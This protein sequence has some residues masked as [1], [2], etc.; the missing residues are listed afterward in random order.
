MLIFLVIILVYSH[1]LFA[2]FNF[3]P[4]FAR[5]IYDMLFITRGK[6]SLIGP[7]TSFGGI[8]SGPYYYYLFVPIFYLTKLNIYSLL[9]FN[10][11]LFLFALI[12]FYIQIAKRYG[13]LSGTLSALVIAFLPIYVTHSRGPWNGS[14]YLPF[15]LIFLTLLFFGEFKKNEIGLLLLGFFAGLIATIHLTNVL[16]LFF[17]SIYLLFL[18]KRKVDIVYFLAGTTLVFSPLILFEFK[19]DFIMLKNTFIIGSYK[20]FIESKNIPPYFFFSLTLLLIFII[21]IFL[22]NI[23]LEYLLIIVLILEIYSFPKNIYNYSP[24][25]PEKY[26]NAVEYV[27]DNKLIQKGESFNIFQYSED[28]KIPVPIGHE[29]RFFFVKN[30]YLPKSEF[31][32]NISDTLLIFSDVKNLDILKLNSW[33]I[34]QFGK[35]YLRQSQKYRIGDI[36]LHKIK[37][38]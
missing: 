9:L 10:L 1:K 26:E 3:H 37:K 38:F 28:Y 21:T 24:R 16:L 7:K 18:I 4:D 36:T 6:L 15:L 5:D 17:A 12:F 30:N 32:Y 23:K 35:Q 34:D 11:V 31:E 29:Y 8:Y 22:L 14:T 20:S 19:H 27:I 33:E 2:S 13:L 25:K